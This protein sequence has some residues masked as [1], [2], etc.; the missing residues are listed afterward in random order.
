M[1][2]GNRQVDVTHGAIHRVAEA[3]N[4]G[5]LQRTSELPLQLHPRQLAPFSGLLELLLGVALDRGPLAGG[6]IAGAGDGVCGD[7]TGRDRR[8]RIGAR[9]MG[10]KSW[11]TIYGS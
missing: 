9:P 11:E 4:H 1:R 5:V 7:P 8:A 3:L 10:T 2:H 6:G